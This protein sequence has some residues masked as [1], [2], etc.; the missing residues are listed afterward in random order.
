MNITILPIKWDSVQAVLTLVRIGSL[1]T[2][3]EVTVTIEFYVYWISGDTIQ[4]VL[5]HEFI[6]LLTCTESE[7]LR[8]SSLCAI[9]GYFSCHTDSLAI[10]VSQEKVRH[11]VAI[12]QVFQT[13]FVPNSIGSSM[14]IIVI[15]DYLL[16]CK[17]SFF[18][19]LFSHHIYIFCREVQVLVSAQANI[20]YISHASHWEFFW[21]LSM[22]AKVEWIRLYCAFYWATH[23]NLCVNRS[24]SISQVLYWNLHATMC[25]SLC[26][27]DSIPSGVVSCMVVTIYP[28]EGCSCS[29][30]CTLVFILKGSDSGQCLVGSDT[31]IYL[32]KT[33]VD[34]V[35]HIDSRLLGIGRTRCDCN[36]AWLHSVS[37]RTLISYF[38]LNSGSSCTIVGD[39]KFWHLVC[40]HSSE[41]FVQVSHIPSF[42]NS[43]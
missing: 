32:F 38:Y 22:C 24:R 15:P 29:T 41:H 12:T 18:I 4:E 34:R 10:G 43:L 20:D 39:S 40:I 5:L 21:L 36:R 16:C 42:A 11:I 30:W 9:E 23:R 13:T 8:G 31:N 19:F 6:P 26:E 14:C 35:Q 25:F 17:A 7:G 1:Y 2:E 37:H 3:G 27:V 33:W 28:I